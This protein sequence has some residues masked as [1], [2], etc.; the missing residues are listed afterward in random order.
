M[1]FWFSK[2][3]CI[4]YSIVVFCFQNF[5]KLNGQDI[6]RGDIPSNVKIHDAYAC[7]EPKRSGFGEKE[8]GEFIKKNPQDTSGFGSSKTIT[9]NKPGDL[10]ADA[11]D[12]IM[13]VDVVK[14]PTFTSSTSSNGYTIYKII[15]VQKPTQVDSKLLLTQ[16][17]QLAQLTT[18]SEAASYF[19]SVKERAGVKN[20]SPIR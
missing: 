9:R 10:S 11:I 17:Q 16:T 19:D 12:A 15:K 5:N 3:I 7:E 2:T 18:Q 1:F 20:I 4:I 6:L 13:G 14:L 8:I